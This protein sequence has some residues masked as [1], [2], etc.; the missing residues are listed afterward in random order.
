LRQPTDIP[1]AESEFKFG[2]V[3][4]NHI[5]DALTEQFL[6]ASGNIKRSRLPSS[7]K[8]NQDRADQLKALIQKVKN[9]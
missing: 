6:R 1:E 8:A 7:V 5:I 3:E 2:T 4:K 9:L